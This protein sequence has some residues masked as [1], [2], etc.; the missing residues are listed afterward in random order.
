M[1][2]ILVPTDFSETSLQ[3]G[4]Y[5][6]HFA[7]QAGATKI[8]LFHPIE[9]YFESGREAK[10]VELG[11]EFYE[12]VVK[13]RQKQLEEL[14]LKLMLFDASIPIETH[15]E[16]VRLIIAINDVCKRFSA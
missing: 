13:D 10:T 6:L 7:K 8:I 1:Q 14:R 15:C 12:H 11:W 16:T 9:N 5:A 4:H 3:T 2:T